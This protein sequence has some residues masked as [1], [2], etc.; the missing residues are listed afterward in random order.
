MPNWGI[1]IVIAAI[2]FGLKDS[3]QERHG[4]MILFGLVV[5]AVFYAALK[6]HTY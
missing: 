6:Q 1:V 3:I 2:F 5:L 4:Y